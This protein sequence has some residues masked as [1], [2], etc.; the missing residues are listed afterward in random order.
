MNED[1]RR[2]C[3]TMASSRLFRGF[4]AEELERV[5]PMLRPVF[6]RYV[7]NQVAIRE[8]EPAGPV[9]IVTGGEFT[10]SKLAND[11]GKYIMRMHSR[12]DLLGLEAVCSTPGTWARTCTCSAGGELLWLDITRLTEASATPE[13]VGVNLRLRDNMLTMLADMTIRLYYRTDVL[14]TNP[15]RDRI[16]LYLKYMRAKH[17]ENAVELRMSITRFA[18]YLAVD[19][20]TLSRELKKLADQGVIERRRDGV[21]IIK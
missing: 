17:G 7:K 12:G 15:L 14:S 1:M 6:R 8:N 10:D 2:A 9:A 20:S 18:A 16:M 11:G 4:S 19:R 3:G 21:L 13:S 5:C